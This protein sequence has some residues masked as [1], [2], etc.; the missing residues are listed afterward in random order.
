MNNQE[1]KNFRKD[2]HDNIELAFLEKH[3]LSLKDYEKVLRKTIKG[4]RIS[5]ESSREIYVY[6][7][8]FGLRNGNLVLTP[9]DDKSVLFRRYKDIETEKMVL[10]SREN[11]RTFES[12]N[13]VVHAISDELTE[14]SYEEAFDIVKY[15]YFK[16]LLHSNEMDAYRLIKRL[17]PTK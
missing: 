17:S 10:I 12:E 16:E 13:Y 7:G 15:R 1:L 11:M 14:E 4:T 8:S 3:R 5:D 6:M 9:K 2:F